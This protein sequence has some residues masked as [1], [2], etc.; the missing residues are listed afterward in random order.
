MNLQDLHQQQIILFEAIS[1][2]LAY[3][4]NLLTSDT[5]LRGV[6]MLPKQTI[7]GLDYQEQVSDTKNDIIFY[8]IKR[9]MQ[10]LSQNSPNM[11]ELLNVPADC[12]LQKKPV[13]DILLNQKDKFITKK[14]QMSFAGYAFQQIKKARGLNKKIVQKMDQERKTPL[15]FCYVVQGYGSL[16][17]S[18]FLENKGWKQEDC[19]LCA[20]SNMRDLYA[21]F[22]EKNANFRGIVHKENANEVCLSNIEQGLTEKAI[23]SFNKD[24]YS[25]YCRS[26]KEYWEWVEKR[27]PD[28]YQENI[29]HGKNYDGKNLMHCHRLLDM[30]IEIAQGQGI[31]VRRPNRE[32]LL[33]IRKGEYNYDQLIAEAEEKIAQ[34]D[35]LFEKSDLPTEIDWAWANELLVEIREEVYKC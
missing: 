19:G 10:L 11:L 1:G 3:G 5:D 33:K 28:R 20:I 35:I 29:E 12:L 15:D 17:L 27:N 13:F 9:F 7:Y 23:I 26:Y 8:E 24:A 4:T 16:A 14:C 25:S 34:I 32:Q 22:Y 2:S 18:K 30:A 31:R 21:L 6:F